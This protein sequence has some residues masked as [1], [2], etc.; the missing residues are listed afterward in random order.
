MQCCFCQ[1]GHTFLTLHLEESHCNS[2]VSNTLPGKVSQ[3]EALMG[4]GRDGFFGLLQLS[5]HGF[6]PAVLR[7][8]SSCC[9]S[10]RNKVL[11][12][13]WN[14]EEG[15]CP[16]SSEQS[17]SGAI[18]S[19]HTFALPFSFSSV[20]LSD[21][22]FSSVTREKKKGEEEL[23]EVYL[24]LCISYHWH[25]KA[26]PGNFRGK[27]FRSQGPC[28]FQ[29]CTYPQ[30]SSLPTLVSSHLFSEKDTQTNNNKINFAQPEELH[31]E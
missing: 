29:G 21:S 19:L 28:S 17:L 23:R 27:Q 3:Q 8:L 20:S 10:C 22:L 9:V 4:V 31:K 16:R 6:S 25:E 2:S 12:Q 5:A 13:G 15:S 1:S 7:F 30:I 24:Q 14:T 18:C 11:L 26:G